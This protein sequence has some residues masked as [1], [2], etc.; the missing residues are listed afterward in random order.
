MHMEKIHQ[1][2]IVKT[3]AGLGVLKLSKC[4]NCFI[5]DPFSVIVYGKNAFLG[6][7][8]HGINV[9]VVVMPK[10]QYCSWGIGEC[11]PNV[12]AKQYCHV[13]PQVIR[14][15]Q[16]SG[17]NIYHSLPSTINHKKQKQ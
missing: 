14:C 5:A 4:I 15:E 17:E 11:F 6:H 9:E 3:F 7:V 1:I 16:V 8:H 10:L 13:C 2:L 12:L